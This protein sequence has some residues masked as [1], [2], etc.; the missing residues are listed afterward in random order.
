[1]AQMIWLA[2]LQDRHIDTLIVP[3]GNEFSARQKVD[4]WKAYHTEQTGDN[5][6]EGKIAGWEYY[7][8][9][10]DDGPSVMIECKD[11]FTVDP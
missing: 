10:G 11:L 5:W 8:S 3:C 1:M 4:E 2:V 9:S 7:A 6:E